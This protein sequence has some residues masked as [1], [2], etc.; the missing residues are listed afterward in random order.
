VPRPLDRPLESDMQWRTLLFETA[1][2]CQVQAAVAVLIMMLMLLLVA[3]R[4]MRGYHRQT[5]ILLR[6][7]AF[8]MI[9]NRPPTDDPM[10]LQENVNWWEREVLKALP[11]AGAESDEIA[12]FTR[13][14]AAGNVYH[15]GM[16]VGK[17]ARLDT[18]ID[19]LERQG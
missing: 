6:S 16:I 9:Q 15:R 18:I 14:G 3:V 13:F 8:H 11:R 1:K 17:I 7:M 5:L 12:Q 10:R 4:W 19:R 2:L